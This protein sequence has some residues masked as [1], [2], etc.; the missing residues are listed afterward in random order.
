MTSLQVLKDKWF[1]DVSAEDRFPPQTRHD[2]T[3][4]QP[5][6]DGNLVVPVIDGAAIMGDFYYRVKE[7]LESDNPDDCQII[8]AAMGIHPIKLLGENGPAKDA[9]ATMLDAAEAGVDVYFLGSGQGNMAIAS[10][11]FAE[12]LIAR[13]SH[14]AIDKRFPGFAV[15]TTR[16]STSHEG[17]MVSGRPWSVRPTSSLLA[18]IH[19]TIHRI[20]QTCHPKEDRLT[21]WD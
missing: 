10:K 15:G 1:V 12:E 20:I 18:G 4:I 19:P 3:Q 8:V 9:M 13:R 6:T 11:K 14:G 21:T 5:Y 2:G 7:M 17:Q 16:N